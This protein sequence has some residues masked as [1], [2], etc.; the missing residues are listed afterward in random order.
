MSIHCKVFFQNETSFEIPV[1]DL[2]ERICATVKKHRT[3]GAY[4]VTVI[5]AD[6]DTMVRLAEEFLDEEDTL[7]DVLSF[8]YSETKPGFRQEQEIENNLL[9]EI[10]ISYTKASEEAKEMEKDP[11]TWILEL[12]EHGTLHLLGIH[13]E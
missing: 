6:D 3:E 13:H 5:L 2:K 10:A 12:A 8:P 7:H 1:E 4:D 9:G 11:V